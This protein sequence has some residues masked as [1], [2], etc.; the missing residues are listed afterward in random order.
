MELEVIREK[1]GYTTLPA[2][3]INEEFVTSS[4]KFD[5]FIAFDEFYRTMGAVRKM[6]QLSEIT[7]RYVK[8]LKEYNFVPVLVGNDDR[9]VLLLRVLEVMD[10][11]LDYEAVREELPN[12]SVSQIDGAFQFIRKMSQI[13]SLDIDLDD[14]EEEIDSEDAELMDALKASLADQENA[15]VLF[16]D[17]QPR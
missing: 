12:L 8:L 2:N 7:G 17:K 9:P 10:E 4:S 6:I 5:Q 11:Q 16:D 3:M 1:T 13:N 15:R 14:L